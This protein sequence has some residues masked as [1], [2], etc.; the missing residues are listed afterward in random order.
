VKVSIICPIFNELRYLPFLLKSF[1]EFDYP[2]DEIEI[3]LIDG[4]SNDGSREYIEQEAKSNK[5]F[6]IYENKRRYQ[7][8]ALNI[9]I[10]ES[11][12]VYIIRCDAHAIYP[13]SYVKELIEILSN[14]KKNIGNAG[15]KYET[16]YHEKNT[17][18]EVIKILLN[19]SFGVG[20]SHRTKR[21]QE[22]IEVDTLL[23]GAW[24]RKI[25]DDV[26]LFD[27]D[28]IRGQ[29][30]EH[31]VRL[32]ANGY[33]II[34]GGKSE[35]KYFGRENYVKFFRMMYQYA[36]AKAFVYKKH[37]KYLN[38]RS[39]I[40]ASFFIIT[41]LGLIYN[42]TAGVVMISAYASLMLYASIYCVK[43]TKS[44]MV[45]IQL[46]FVMLIQHVSHA[47]GLIKGFL[48][49]FIFKSK[50]HMEHTR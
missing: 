3:L 21:F 6:K 15:L 14:Q 37:R 36:Y 9:G 4:G 10:K 13:K 27:E 1:N 5:I 40:P 45:G 39:F 32:K 47:Y 7:V 30:Y 50:M 46:P 49:A 26:G 8:Y 31:N 38:I 24:P 48:D 35:F 11:K 12:G 28:F 2:K 42:I 34:I 22:E 41:A 20:V 16:I 17:T 29:D 33:K 25:F 19:S 43:N 44:L 18:S 23:F